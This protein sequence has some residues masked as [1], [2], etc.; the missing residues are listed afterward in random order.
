MIHCYGQTY[1]RRQWGIL[2]YSVTHAQFR[3]ASGVVVD[4]PRLGFS[5]GI[6]DSPDRVEPGPPAKV[7]VLCQTRSVGRCHCQ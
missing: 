6:V 2:L 5:R 1:H 3:K 7:Y 4:R